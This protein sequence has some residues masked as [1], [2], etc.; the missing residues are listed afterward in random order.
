MRSEGWKPHA[1]VIYIAEKPWTEKL[2]QE[3]KDTNPCGVKGS[4]PVPTPLTTLLRAHRMGEDGLLKCVKAADIDDLMHRKIFTVDGN[5]R[6]AHMHEMIEQK[7]QHAQH[8]IP[9]GVILL[10]WVWDEKELVDLLFMAMDTNTTGE[11]RETDTLLDKM[12]QLKGVRSSI[13]PFFRSYCLIHV[14]S[15]FRS[16]ILAFLRSCVFV[17][18]VF[19]AFVSSRS[20]A[21]QE[22]ANYHCRNQEK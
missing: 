9:H 19:T 20:L 3:Y 22:L 5:H 6:C 11:H 18:Y 7:H 17:H 13:L 8:L 12:T 2:W 4:D 14:N 16:F 21:N 10:D 15:F 1:G